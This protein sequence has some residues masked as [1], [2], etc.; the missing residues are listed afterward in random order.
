MWPMIY[1]CLSQLELHVKFL[2][3][4]SH[5]QQPKRLLNLAIRDTAVESANER[6]DGCKAENF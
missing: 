3:Q 1:T 6:S 5:W 2:L 4:L